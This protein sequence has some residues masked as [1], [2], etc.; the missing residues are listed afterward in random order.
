M[1]ASHLEEGNIEADRHSNKGVQRY[2]EPCTQFMTCEIQSPV[3]LS[4]GDLYRLV[5]CQAIPQS[6]CIFKRCSTA[7]IR[8]ASYR[9]MACSTSDGWPCHAAAFTTGATAIDLANACD[10]QLADYG[11]HHSRAERSHC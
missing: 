3:S 9:A 1:E 4:G 7:S 10:R 8:V 6:P 11:A 5:G 2:Q